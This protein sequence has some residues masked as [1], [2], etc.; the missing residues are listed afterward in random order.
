M[1]FVTNAYDSMDAQTYPCTAQELCDE[2]GHLELELPA[3]A[4]NL[5][6]VL[7]VVSEEEFQTEQEARQATYGLLGEKAIGRKGYS[8]R[9]PVAVGEDGPERVSL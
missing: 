1:R 3:G 8:D 7:N 6:D 9:D 2:Y 5:E 4:V